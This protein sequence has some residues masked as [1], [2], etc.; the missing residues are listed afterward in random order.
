MSSPYDDQI[1]ELLAQYRDAR[2]Q[3]V[4]SRGRINEVEATVTAPRQVVKVTVGAQGQVTGLDFPTAAYRNLPPKDLSKAILA[5]IEQ[6]RA[7]AM[8]KVVEALGDTMPGMPAG[9]SLTDMLQ[10]RFDPRALLPEE[11]MLPDAVR[12]YVDNGSGAKKGSGRRD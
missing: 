1:E 5:A 2:E 11:L 3:A 10:G 9:V 8:A 12:E 4:E 6:A 7:Q